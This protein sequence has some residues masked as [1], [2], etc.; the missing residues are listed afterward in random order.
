[1]RSLEFRDQ[2]SAEDFGRVLSSA[3]VLLVNER[4]ELSDMAVPSKLTSYFMSGRPV[5]AATDA[6]SATSSQLAAAERECGS[7]PAIRSHC[8]KE[9]ASPGST[10]AN[11]RQPLYFQLIPRMAF[12]GLISPG[13]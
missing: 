7:I 4:P 11:T 2:V 9:D 1:M 6:A 5:L 12:S 13:L 8:S 3:D 10:W